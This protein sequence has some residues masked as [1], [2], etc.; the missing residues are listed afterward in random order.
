MAVSRLT[1]G[2]RCGHADGGFQRRADHG[3]RHA[4]RAGRL[5]DDL[6]RNIGDMDES[7]RIASAIFSTGMVAKYAAGPSGQTGVSRGLAPRLSGMEA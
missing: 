2:M 5:I 3:Q 1:A 7:A 4:G 6:F